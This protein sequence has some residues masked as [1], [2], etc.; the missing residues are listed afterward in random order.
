MVATV[1]GHLGRAL[2]SS[3]ISPVVSDVDPAPP[4]VVVL[5]VGVD[6]APPEAERPPR[7]QAVLVGKELHHGGE[8]GSELL[9][10]LEAARKH[11]R[12]IRF[13]YRGSG[14]RAFLTQIDDVENEGKGNNWI[15]RVNKKL[16]E[17]SFAVTAVNAGDVILWEFGEYK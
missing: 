11:P 6:P 10:V 7:V 16:G 4:I 15:F 5:V 1:L 3:S 9:D 17:E 13:K 2:S 8:A 14:K 12:G